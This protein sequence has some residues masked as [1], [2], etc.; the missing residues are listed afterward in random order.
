MVEAFGGAD[1]GVSSAGLQN[2]PTAAAGLLA[3]PPFHFYVWWDFANLN[4]ADAAS[5]A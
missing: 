5:Q 1:T 3:P 4:E 2:K